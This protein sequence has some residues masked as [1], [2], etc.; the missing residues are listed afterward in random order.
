[1][2]KVILGIICLMMVS[3]LALLPYQMKIERLQTEAFVVGGAGGGGSATQ[4]N[5]ALG[6]SYDT[7]GELDTL[8][9]ARCLESTF[10]DTLGTGLLL[11]GTTLS[12]SAILQ[13]YHGVNPTVAGL[14][15]LDDAAASNQ[16]TTLGLVI[17]T[18]VQAQD[19]D[20]T[21]IAGADTWMDYYKNGSAVLTDLALGAQYK[22]KMSNGAS[23]AP[24]WENIAEI[25]LNF[26]DLTTADADTS[27]HGLM[28]K[29]NNVAYAYLDGTG[30]WRNG[31]T[32]P[33]DPNKDQG[34]F[35]D[36]SEGAFAYKELEECVSWTIV[37]SDAVTAVADG[38]QAWAVPAK[39]QGFASSLWN[40]VDVTASVADLNSAGSGFTTVVLRRVRGGTPQDMTSTGVTI[41]HDAYTES[42]ETVNTS[43]DDLATGDNIYVDVNAVTSAVHKGLSVTATFRLVVLP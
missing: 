37:D 8:F 7:S 31:A 14:A 43:Y 36:D 26:T 12:V 39:L 21:N 32:V 19:A 18:N 11:T 24:S 42:D 41:A 15:L 23:S 38:L 27:A 35:W 4:V 10:G 5:D 2:K 20:L 30:T 13:E 22:F 28:P 16:R 17:G 25:H 34:L 3:Y 29:L 1:M 9:N 6:D 33:A 40:L